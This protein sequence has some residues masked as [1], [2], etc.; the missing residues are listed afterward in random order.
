[1]RFSNT[2]RLFGRERAEHDHEREQIMS[3]A[4]PQPYIDPARI[5]SETVDGETLVIDA[6]TGAYYVL[7]GSGAVIWQLLGQGCT[8]PLLL[9]HVAQRYGGA[10]VD[11]QLAVAR[12]LDELQQAELII[13]PAAGLATL[14]MATGVTVAPARPLPTT[15]APPELHR[16]TDM[17]DLL[18]IDPIHEVTASGWPF[19]PAKAGAPYDR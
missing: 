18:L 8:L 14:A 11:L 6:H 3:E 10:V 9:E 2:S 5:I 17:H 16:F 1:M 4:A 15:F 19:T 13:L 7:R 12:F